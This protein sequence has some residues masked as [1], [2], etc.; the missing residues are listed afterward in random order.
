[1]SIFR[2]LLV[3]IGG[4]LV[5]GFT[6]LVLALTWRLEELGASEASR[7]RAALKDRVA[8]ELADKVDVAWALVAACHA[9]T[10]TA[11]KPVAEAQALCAD[12]VRRA[13]FGPRERSYFWIHSFDAGAPGQ[14]RMVMHPTMPALD[15]KDV[16]DFVDR[17]RFQRISFRGRVLDASAPEVRDVPATNLF[18]DM[19]RA[20]SAN[21]RGVVDYYWPDPQRDMT[22]GYAKMSAVRL[23]EPWGWVVGTGEYYDHVDEVV[24]SQQAVFAAAT[25]ATTLRL[26]LA[27]GVIFA[28]ILA[29]IIAAGRTMKQVVASAADELARLSDAVDAGRL[30]VRAS[31]DRV[32]PEL[33]P[34]IHGANTIVDRFARPLAVIS[35]YLARLAKGDV[36]PRL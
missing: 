18:V 19:N 29:S 12:R 4:P 24:A 15:G 27:S 21:G 3:G 5:I 11:G 22:V 17:R 25:R 34:I 30:Q 6:T 8:A 26:E 33:Q 13:R 28:I 10:A 2:R 7:S 20:V 1:M 35:D 23:F 9:E 32:H 36:P 14:P 31:P 16:S